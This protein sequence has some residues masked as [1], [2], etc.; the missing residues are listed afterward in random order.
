MSISTS[1]HSTPTFK[2]SAQ[3]NVCSQPRFFRGGQDSGICYMGWRCKTGSVNE[4]VLPAIWYS[5]QKTT[6]SVPL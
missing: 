1:P 2:P 5:C 4:K 3:P 6:L